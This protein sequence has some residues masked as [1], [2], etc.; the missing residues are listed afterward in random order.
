MVCG[1]SA[2]NST[3]QRNPPFGI[4]L[5]RAI[6]APITFPRQRAADTQTAVATSGETHCVFPSL[7]IGTGLRGQA[8]IGAADCPQIHSNLLGLALGGQCRRRR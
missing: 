2:R 5:P 6:I 4:A 8:G 1:S 7:S 3:R